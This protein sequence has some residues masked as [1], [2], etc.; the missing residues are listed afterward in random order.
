MS[1]SVPLGSPLRGGMGI[2]AGRELKTRM[3]RGPRA[4]P[5]PLRTP[6]LRAQL[7]NPLETYSCGARK[8]LEALKVF[9]FHQP[10][11]WLASLTANINSESLALIVPPT[12][13]TDHCHRRS[14]KLRRAH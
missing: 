2:W 8:T 13:C 10:V 5:R 14:N 12:S 7:S 3:K 9:S 6:R 11:T 4:V 1:F